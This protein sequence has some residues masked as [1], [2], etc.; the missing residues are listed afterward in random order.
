MA[1][2][3]GIDHFLAYLK[4]LE[5][6]YVVIGGGAAA[7]L[8]E[9]QDLEFRR[10]KDVDLVLLTNGS[11]ELNSRI[12]QYVQDGKYQLKEATEG[13]PRYYL[14][15]KPE[16]ETY[17]EIIEIFARN[18]QEIALLEGQYIIPVQNDS[19]AKISAIL[20]DEEYFALIKANSRQTASGGS[21]V[22][23]LGNICLKARA[24]RELSERKSKGES[25]DDKDIRKHRNDILRLA[26]S[27]T[28]QE[29]LALGPTSKAD[30]KMAMGELRAMDAKQFKQV[31][32]GS[33]G[34]SQHDLLHLIGE[35]FDI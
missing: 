27:L 32:E 6:Q 4:G 28:G 30:L 9:E 8:L 12:S 16:N 21:I 1:R 24:H 10:T 15:Q 7:I 18:E 3:R 22:N 19:V 13:A 35:V 5:N 31:L 23:A 14:F 2:P 33:P 25:V 17:P 20:L 29:R 34:V 26:V 11:N